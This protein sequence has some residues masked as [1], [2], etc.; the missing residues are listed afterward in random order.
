[1]HELGIAQNILQIVQ[2]SVP[3]K[4]ASDVRGIRIRVG[5]LSGVVPASLDF[6]FSAIINDTEMRKAR[7]QIEQVPLTSECRECKH[8]FQM[9]DLAFFCPE[10]KST[11]LELISGRELEILEIEL[12]DESGEGP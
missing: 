2:Q 10:C 8:R 11:N 9:E 5:Q 1:M 6:C 12:A 3:E 7:L 4:Q